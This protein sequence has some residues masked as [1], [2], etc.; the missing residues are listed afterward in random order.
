[1]LIQGLRSE[2]R[3]APPTPQA[4]YFFDEQTLYEQYGGTFLFDIEVYRNFFFAGFKCYNTGYIVTLERSE[5]TDFN[6][7]M[8]KWILDSIRLVGFNSLTYD[9]P[10][11]WAALA[12]YPCDK[13]KA[14][15]DFIIKGNHRPWQVE[16][17]FDFKMG[18]SNHIDLFS[19]APGSPQSTSLKQYMARLGAPYLQDLPY[20]HNATLT[21]DEME[22]VKTYNINDL[23]GTGFLLK[24]LEKPIELRER[25]GLRYEIDL[26]SK[27]DAQIAEAVIAHEIESRQGKV[28]RSPK[29]AEGTEITYK[30]PKWV[31]FY[32]PVL[33]NLLWTLCS[34]KMIVDENGQ[35]QFPDP[36]KKIQIHIGQT[37]YTIGRGGLHSCEQSTAH[38]AD[39]ETMLIDRDVAS[40]YPCIILNQGWYPEHI[41][42]DFLEVYRELYE[43]RIQAKDAKDK[44]TS[45]SLKIVIN[46]TFGKTSNK[47]SCI[48]APWLLIHI[49]LTGQL[50][51]L[52]LIEMLEWI[53]IPVIS[54]NTDGVVTRVPNS[55][56]DDYLQVCMDW[57][58]ITGFETEETR[59]ASLWAENVNSYI[60]IKTDGEIKAKGPMI[61][62]LA[63]KP[64][65]RE[66]MTSNPTGDIVLVAVK[67]FLRDRMP[68]EKTIRACKDIRQFLFVRKV[69]GGAVKDGVYL[70]R[71]V[72]WYM[73]QHEYGSIN[74]ATSGNTVSDSTGGMPLMEIPQEIP[75]DIDYDWYIRKADKILNL[76]GYYGNPEK[77]LDLFKY[78]GN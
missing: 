25:L 57:E 15:S 29:I 11:L 26:R 19:V 78:Q 23:D 61:S 44:V 53:G 56:Y 22:V 39:D 69:K 9:M 77:Q 3:L 48:Y 38:Q 27:S 74:Y 54:A 72:R 59:Y 31:K 35:V 10:I 64:D 4:V 55:R 37:K 21:K 34:I 41:G 67:K 5:F 65:S 42:P 6:P 14:V 47:Y 32:T 49:T 40:Y 58:R 45:D 63:L 70:G 17:E 68:V 7:A 8:L 12:G 66:W 36:Y 46:G 71:V 75:T 1:M 28:P 60:A 33:Q 50:A 20:H 76:I 51:L 18:Y 73:R 2:F 13:L 43:S 30:P 16:R 24:K 52:M 62:P